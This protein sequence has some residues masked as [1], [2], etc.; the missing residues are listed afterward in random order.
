M[1]T[2]PSRR[3]QAVAF[4]ALCLSFQAGLAQNGRDLLPV[5]VNHK[6]GCIDSTGKIVIPIEY[7]FAWG[8]A[9]GLAPAWK[10][11]QAGYIDRSGKFVIPAQFQYARG[12]AQG[13]AAVELGE[14]WGY[15]DKTE[16][17]KFATRNSADILTGRVSP[18]G[19][20]DSM[21]SEGCAL[22][23]PGKRQNR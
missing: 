16:W 8:F 11:Q 15:I 23:V 2:N 21:K 14:E 3:R 22:L 13:L 6:Y 7:D 18:S 5:Q 20:R 1:P 9:G 10:G 17:R 19:P 4:M 12:F